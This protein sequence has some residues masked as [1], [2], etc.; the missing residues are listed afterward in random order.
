MK[1][2]IALFVGALCTTSVF[3]QAPVPP[4]LDLDL[5][6]KPNVTAADSGSTLADD[7]PGTYYGDVSGKDEP[8]SHTTM[9][10]SVTTTAG[11]AKGYGSGFATGAQLNVSTQ[12][13]NGKVIQMDIGVMRSD[14]LPNRRGRGYES[15]FDSI[16]DDRR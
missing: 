16:L 7:P 2:A 15:G 12:L 11:Y 10:G 5:A 1:I 8:D 14:G 6:S 3:A 13:K 9:S 4:A